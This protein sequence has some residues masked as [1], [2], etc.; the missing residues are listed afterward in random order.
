MVASRI[1]GKNA[2]KKNKVCHL[3]PSPSTFSNF[4]TVSPDLCS[5]SVARK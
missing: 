1:A 3:G 4:P 5:K 2:M